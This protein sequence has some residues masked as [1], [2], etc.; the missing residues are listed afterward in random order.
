MILGLVFF[1]YSDF[2]KKEED[3]ENK[4]GTG[5]RKTGQTVI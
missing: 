4:P 2:L 3:H 1:S 5:D